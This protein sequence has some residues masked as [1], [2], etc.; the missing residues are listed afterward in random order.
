MVKESGFQW[1]VHQNPSR[2][3]PSWALEIPQDIRNHTHAVS[4]SPRKSIKTRPGVWLDWRASFSVVPIRSIPSRGLR[5]K[6]CPRQVPFRVRC[7]ILIMSKYQFV[8]DRVLFCLQTGPPLPFD[9]LISNGSCLFLIQHIWVGYEFREGDQIPRHLRKKSGQ[10]V[11]HAS[12]FEMPKFNG[13]TLDCI[14]LP[15]LNAFFKVQTRS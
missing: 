2:F 13:E 15:F 6:V 12:S 8:I 11:A 14:S 1:I 9:S 7:I 5:K 10:W 4:R 3:A